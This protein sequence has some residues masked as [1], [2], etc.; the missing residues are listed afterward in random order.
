MKLAH[1]P[2][3]K[4][5]RPLPLDF[6]EGLPGDRIDLTASRC[7]ADE[8]RTAVVGVGHALDIAVAFETG[9]QISHRLLGDLGPPR[10][11]AHLVSVVIH[12]QRRVV[13]RK[14]RL[15]GDDLAGWIRGVFRELAKA[16]EAG[17]PGPAAYAAASEEYGITWL[18]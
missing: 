8:L 1:L 11:L 9:D 13:P 12:S 5:G 2:R 18:G 15:L 16:E 10:E 3:A 7:R 4:P 14:G 17:T 6:G